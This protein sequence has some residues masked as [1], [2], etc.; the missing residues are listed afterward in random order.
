MLKAVNSTSDGTESNFPVGGSCYYSRNT[1]K[2]NRTKQ[3][4]RQLLRFSVSSQ[5][6]CLST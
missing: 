5:G 4:S 2:W 3:G 1:S 6:I